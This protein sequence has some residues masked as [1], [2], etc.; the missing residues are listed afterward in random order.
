MKRVPA[1]DGLRGVA[2][3]LV[4]IS[5]FPDSPFEFA[6]SVGVT[7]FFVLSGFLITR[8]LADELDQTGAVSLRRF[9]ARRARRLFPALALMLA[10]LPVL[11]DWTLAHTWERS[12]PTVLY[13][14]NVV[15]LWGYDLVP[16]THT[17]SLAV[18]EHF[19]V[20]WP[21]VVAA[22]AG[23]RR[24]RW[25]AALLVGAFAWRMVL[26]SSG[27]GTDRIYFGTDTNAYA[28]L[29]G[30]TLAVAGRRAVGRW[31]APA[32]VCG[33]VIL[34]LSG[35]DRTHFNSWLPIAVVLSVF[36]VNGATGSV[37]LLEFSVLR[38][39]GTISYGLYL[40]HYPIMRSDLPTLTMVPLTFG[41]AAVS[42]MA[43]ERPILRRGRA[44]HIR[45]GVLLAF[46]RV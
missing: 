44:A 26:A 7:L 24:L 45:P 41:I 2:I 34:G 15:R 29:A 5:H 21:I 28:L 4:L 17:W 42:W 12:W 38:W 10:G 9:Y 25:T 46:R 35:V 16:L 32:M 11:F 43:V 39:I 33:L 22:M 14:A 13:L 20:L 8:L 18:E 1:L 37:P 30:C 23:S 6:G 3:L 36:A 19:Y 40:W 31:V 27:A